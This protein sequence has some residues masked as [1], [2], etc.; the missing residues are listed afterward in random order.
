MLF[1]HLQ[2]TPSWNGWFSVNYTINNS[3]AIKFSTH[4]IRGP[5][6][7]ILGL[8]N[9]TAMYC[10]CQG[11]WVYQWVHIIPY[12]LETWEMHVMKWGQFKLLQIFHCLK[13]KMSQILP[14]NF[15]QIFY[16]LIHTLLGFFLSINSWEK[17]L[18]DNINTFTG[19]KWKILT[20]KVIYI[21]VQEWLDSQEHY[22]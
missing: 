18:H 2:S 8:K 16:V 20:R 3:S 19:E 7:Q 15:S 5:K 1:S 4:L 17:P 11:S 10:F 12:S 13:M 6:W 21:S 22:R 9:V 14:K